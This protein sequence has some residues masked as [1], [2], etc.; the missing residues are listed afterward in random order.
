MKTRVDVETQERIAILAALTPCGSGSH[1]DEPG[2]WCVECVKELTAKPE[3]LSLCLELIWWK[4]T[5]ESR[6]MSSDLHTH[7]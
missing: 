3:S 7:A 4:E 1:D 5:S 2:R 6:K